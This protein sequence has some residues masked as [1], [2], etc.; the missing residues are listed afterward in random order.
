VFEWDN[1][2]LD[3]IA[4]HGVSPEEAEEAMDDRY[5]IT[6][7]AY[8]FEGERRRGTIG[9]TRNGRILYVVYTVRAGLLRVVTVRP[10]TRLERQRYGERR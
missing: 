9:M 7:P 8:D 5:Q 6:A 1:G 4:N 10:A 3:H 2:N